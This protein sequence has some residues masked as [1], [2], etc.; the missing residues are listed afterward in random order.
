MPIWRSKHRRA[1]Q[2]S[3]EPQLPPTGF[4]TTKG[5]FEFKPKA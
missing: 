2:M 5:G 1:I 3:G 4:E